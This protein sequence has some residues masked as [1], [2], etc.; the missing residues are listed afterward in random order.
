MSILAT[1]LTPRE[2]LGGQPSGIM[3]VV[4]SIAR[5]QLS[6]VLY[7]AIACTVLRLALFPYLVRVEPHRRFG[8]YRVARF[9]NEVLDAL[10]YAGVFVFLVIRPF[11]IQTFF[12]PSGSM[13]DTLQ[14]NDYIIANKF[15]YRVREPQVG[16]IIVFKP[17]KNALE[18]GQGDQDF[19]KRVV[20][21]PG[22]VVEIRGGELYRDGQRVDEPYVK[23]RIAFRD[24]KLVKDGDRYVPLTISGPIVNTPDYTKPP[25]VVTEPAEMD[26]LLSLPAAPVPPGHLLVMGDN[27]NGS[28]DS[29]AWGLVP[30]RSVIG[31]SEIVWWPPRRWKRT[32]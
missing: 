30:I 24:F 32:L 14:L 21:A 29:R 3:A 18:P 13:L 22:N 23:D 2:T 1:L 20:G 31:R 26:R 7:F 12:I 16:E 10:V 25:Y 17:P 28:S 19:I 11:V 6:Y 9:V 15:I 27:R 8:L 5:T 4:D